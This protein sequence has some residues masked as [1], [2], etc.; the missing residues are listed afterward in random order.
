VELQPGNVL[1]VF[2]QSWTMNDPWTDPNGVTGPKYAM[3]GNALIAAISPVAFKLNAG[4]IFFPTSPAPGFL[5]LCPADVA[6]ITQAPPQIPIVQAAQFVNLWRQHFA[7]PWAAVL[8]TPLHKGLHQADLALRNP[9]GKTAMVI[10]TDGHWTCGDGTEVAT[11]SGLLARGIKTYVVGLPGAYGIV[12]LDG[13]AQAGGTAKPGCSQNCFL[14]PTN[15]KELE[16]E[17]GKIA[18]ETVTIT[19]CTI[20]LNPPPPAADKVHLVIRDGSGMSFEVPR[21]DGAGNGWTL[22][23][24]GKTATLTGSICQNAKDGRFSDLRFEYG[25]VNLPP[26]R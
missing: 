8:G 22:S 18:T 9:P 3:A 21:D 19:S 13:L 6:P 4:A 23:P 16:Q 25:C 12:G 24:D 11:V 26:L 1:V 2:D 10:F 20:T 14:I 5:D 7:P 17:L 15:V